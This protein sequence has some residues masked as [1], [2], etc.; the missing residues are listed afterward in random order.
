MGEERSLQLIFKNLFQNTLRHH[1]GQHKIIE[2]KLSKKIGGQISLIYTDH[3]E[4]FSG[5]ASRLGQLFY[6]HHSKKGSGIGLYL[7][8]QLMKAMKG[9]LVIDSN[10]ELLFEL[11]FQASSEGQTWA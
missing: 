7:I 6:R 10:A 8:K 5:D 11:C 2:L 1:S 3:G 4:P 9:K